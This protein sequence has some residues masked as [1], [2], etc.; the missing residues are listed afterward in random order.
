QKVQKTWNEKK[1]QF[2]KLIQVIGKSSR[3]VEGELLELKDNLAVI[4]NSQA[5]LHDDLSGFHRRQD[6]RDFLEDRLTVLNWL[7]PINYAAQQS[8]F[9]C[10]RQARTGQWLLDSRE[11]KTWV[12]TERQTLFCPCIPGAGKTILT[13][14]VINELTTRFI[15]DNNISIVYLYCNFRRQ[16]NQM[17]E[18]LLTN[19]LK[20]MCQ[21]QSS[22][23]ESVK[24]LQNSHKDAGTNP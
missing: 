19:L 17:A 9:I 18:D 6:N 13:S 8:D 20:Q 23:P 14:I 22:L 21:G 1:K 24:A 15:D 11:L 2:M 3:E 7:T 12:E 4:Q 10:W 5:Y 16:D